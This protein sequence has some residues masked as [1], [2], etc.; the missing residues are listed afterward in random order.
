MNAQQRE[1]STFLT[2]GAIPPN[3]AAPTILIS[4]TTKM[5]ETTI[6]LS[7][8]TSQTVTTLKSRTVLNSIGLTRGKT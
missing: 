6:R 7:K 3:P 8:A 1:L 5:S 4:T 2:R